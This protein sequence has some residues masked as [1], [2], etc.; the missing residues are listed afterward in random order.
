MS[1]AEAAHGLACPQ[2][3]GVVPIP[4]GMVIVACPY[5]GLRSL[6]R[7][8]RGLRRYQVARMA[9]R[10]AAVSAMQR[11]LSSKKAIAGDAARQATL[12]EAFV[13]YLPFWAVWARALG[14]AFGQKRV[15]SGDKA[16]Y[17]PREVRT[18]Q[19]L[20]WNGAACDVGEFG[21][22]EI[23]LEGRTLEPFDPPRLHETGMVFEPAGSLSEAQAAAEADFQD[24][25]SRSAR[26]DRINQVFSRL[27]RKRLGLVYYPLWVL[28]YLYRGRAFQVVVDGFSGEV[29][30]GK[31]PGST[32]YRAAVLVGGMAAGALL[33]VDGTA[34]AF[35]LGAQAEG[36]T[37][38]ALFF[39]GIIA[40]IA[41]FGLMWAA[42]R[43]FRF[44]EQY[45][46]QRKGQSRLF[47]FQQPRQ[48]LSEIQELTR[49]S[50]LSH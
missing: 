22:T 9:A 13:V 42:Y 37:A 8:E 26:L 31:A 41:G 21:V 49:W 3:G 6:V 2:C 25:L 34:L 28:R 17:E 15:G 44:G 11:F 20:T 35:Y 29:L 33:A 36:D 14:W 46:Y 16:R 43:A 24:R 18:A 4:E 47:N 10:E 48:I 23:T 19:D 1:A 12:E 27:V 5:C 7:G 38:S 50:N 39:G 40:L 30:Y 32:L 45:E